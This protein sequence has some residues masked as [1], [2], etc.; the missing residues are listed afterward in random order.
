M[1]TFLPLAMFPASVAHLRS[2][3]SS[4]PGPSGLPLGGGRA[5]FAA[6]P[7][8]RRITLPR[9]D[10]KLPSRVGAYC[11]L[12][13]IVTPLAVSSRG[14]WVR[15]GRAPTAS[16]ATSA[17]VGDVDADDDIP[18]TLSAACGKSLQ[19]ALPVVIGGPEN[20]FDPIGPLN[21]TP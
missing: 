5:V 7:R 16:A 11:L 19:W 10:K 15:H 1:G 12:G 21:Y 14:S 9:R 3:H 4:R 13:V 8:E 17:A 18:I 6:H 2:L 20:L